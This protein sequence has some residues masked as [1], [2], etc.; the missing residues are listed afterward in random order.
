MSTVST[1]VNSNS[2]SSSSTIVG[3][4]TGP[5]ARRLWPPPKPARSPEAII[6]NTAANLTNSWYEHKI[7]V[8]LL[9]FK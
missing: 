4:G 2:S 7:C 8:V 3:S 1:I 9:I 6:A 5:R